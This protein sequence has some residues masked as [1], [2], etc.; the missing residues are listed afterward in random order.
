VF[1]DENIY[2]IIR[3]N[4]YIKRLYFIFI[5]KMDSFIENNKEKSQPNFLNVFT[6]FT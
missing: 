2:S 4:V 1:S 6:I 3:N 5:F